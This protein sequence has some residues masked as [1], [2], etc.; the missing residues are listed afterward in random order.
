MIEQQPLRDDVQTLHVLLDQVLTEQ[1]GAEF[2][3]GLRRLQQLARERRAG[4]PGA[5]NRLISSISAMSGEHLEIAVRA[6]SLEFDLAN[7][8]ED[9]QRVRVLAERRQRDGGQPGRESIAAAVAQLSSDG[10]SAEEVEHLLS[11]L[12][13]DLVFTAHPTEA[14]RRATRRILRRLREAM[15]ARNPAIGLTANPELF[16]EKILAY[17][18][19]LWQID[20]IRPQRPTVM[21][22]VERGLFFFDGLWE[23]VPLIQQEMRAALARYYPDHAFPAAR[24]LRFGSWIG[25]DRDGNP[26]VTAAVTE[27]TLQRLRKAAVERHLQVCRELAQLIVLSSASQP[28]DDG[29]REAIEKALGQS[30]ELR[31]F[32]ESIADVELYR[33]WLGVIE[34][35]LKATLAA[36]S[37]QRGETW[38]Y[39][40]RDDLSQDVE[41]LRASLRQNGGERIAQILLGD[42]LDQIRTFGLQF[43]A[44]DVRQDS[45][46]HVDVL[47]EIFQATGLCED[48][49]Q[50]DEAARVGVLTK[51][52]TIGQEL[53][54]HTLSETAQECLA[55]FQLLTRTV[56]SQGAERLG[57]FVISMSHAPS[58]VLAV[59]WLWKWAWR[60]TP[61][62][63]G[64]PLAYLPI[65][66]LLE[67]IGDLQHGPEILSA[68]FAEPTYQ[69]YLK[70]N[71]QA[72]PTQMVMVGYSDST[73]DGGYL[74]ASWGLFRAQ[75]QL[76]DVTEAAGIRLVAFHGRGGALG[77]GGGPAARAILSLPSRSVGG[78]LRITEQGEVL[79]ERYDDP[80]IAHRHLEQVTWATMLVSGET[81]EAPPKEWPALMEQLA[82]RSYRQYRSLVEDPGFIQYFDQATPIADIERLPIGSRPS[83]RR[84]RKSLADLRAIPWTF[85]WTQSRQFIPAWYGLGTAIIEAVE[86]QGGDWSQFQ[87]M[88][89][90]WP[91]FRATID[92]ATLALS[93]AD[94]AIAQRYSELLEDPATGARL[95][96]LVSQEFELSRAAVLMIAQ[97]PSLLAGTP[98]LQ[99][100]IQ[101][102]NP[103]VDPLNLIQIELIRRTRQAVEAGD[104]ATENRLRELIRLTIQGVAAGLRTTG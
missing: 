90:Q 55:L 96:G 88:Y 15:Q 44:L 77:R 59:L 2:V 45:R 10:V 18:T 26:Y 92:N 25:G 5:E 43:A 95:W 60:A 31:Q 69:E 79:A 36:S 61:D 42:W 20:P 39:R 102:R 34:F 11:R 41:L 24:F 48:Y 9:L 53:L 76:A 66:P 57:G 75:E 62:E 103:S 104:E 86:A 87:R 68:L 64:Q 97:E 52:S 29:L 33:R 100:S 12:D 16:R 98:W 1:V 49:S 46:V 30:S 40:S 82:E 91:L 8:S 93:K 4:L 54:E 3:A 85:A 51:P 63:G 74:A 58:D 27:E 22:E 47:T 80:R 99:Q 50:C 38:I 13:V 35:R 67:T 84:E 72:V 70:S 7:L 6:L 56:R 19:L 21:Q 78:T 101:E 73:K 65:M 81:A 28:V 89:Q 23:V 17:L 94:L 83:R 71:P 14:K 32:V 37:T